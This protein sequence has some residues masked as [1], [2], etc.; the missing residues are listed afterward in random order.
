MGV[1][2]VFIRTSGC[3]LRCS[4]CDTPYTSWQPEGDGADASTRSWTKSQISRGQARG[5][6]RRRAD[7]RARNRAR[8]PAGCAS[9]VCTSPSK[10][11]GP[12]SQPVAC[13]LMSISPKLSNSTPDGPFRAQHER[14]RIQP[15]T[16]RRLMDLCDYQLKFVIAQEADIG[17]MQ[18]LSEHLGAPAGKVILMPEGI[19]AETLEHARSMAGRSLQGH[20]YRFSPRLHV[21]ALGQQARHLTMTILCLASY[22]KGHRFIAEAKKQ[23]ATVVADHFAQSEREGAAGR[24][25][26]STKSITCRTATSSGTGSD[27]LNAVSYLGRNARLRPHRRPGRFR[28]RNR[29]HAARAPAGDGVRRDHGAFLPRQTGHAREGARLRHPGSRFPPCAELRPAARVHGPGAWAVGAE[30][31]LDGGFDRDQEDRQPGRVLARGCNWAI[32]SRSI[33]WSALCPATFSMS[34]ALSS[35]A[36]CGS[37]SPAVTAARRWRFRTKAGSL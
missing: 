2:S 31:A 20:G 1:P 6:H 5:D 26:V 33:C 34:T 13:D 12:C 24:S 10:R 9:A 15:E 14:L 21:H 37:P 11:R 3:N 35:M 23:G 27:L 4:W 19:D 32:C 28:C 8:S 22:E 29:G 36:R 7:D 16:L 17:E 18:A 25:K 30:A